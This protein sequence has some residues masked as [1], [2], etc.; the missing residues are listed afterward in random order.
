MTI[1]SEIKIGMMINEEIEKLESIELDMIL[2]RLDNSQLNA[3][4]SDF[5]AVFASTQKN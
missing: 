2:D 1:Q 3:Q 5:F 4:V